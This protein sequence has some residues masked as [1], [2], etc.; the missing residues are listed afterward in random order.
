MIDTN[1][2]TPPQPETMTINGRATSWT[3]GCNALRTFTR[4]DA[5]VIAGGL[6]LKA[7][8]AGDS[9]LMLVE[10]NFI[11]GRR[12]MHYDMLLPPDAGPTLIGDVNPNGTTRLLFAPDA[13]VHGAAAL[14]LTCI[15][16]AQAMVEGGLDPQCP[17]PNVSKMALAESGAFD[18]PP[19]TI[20]ELAE[21]PVLSAG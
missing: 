2:H 21:L 20:G 18:S 8:I 14:R 15:A 1:D 9:L 10:P 7:A 19:A 5:I 13:L 11:N 12:V 6:L 17:L 16:V 3:E 4:P